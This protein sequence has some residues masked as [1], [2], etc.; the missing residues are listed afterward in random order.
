MATL[1]PRGPDRF[2]EAASLLRALANPVRLAI[3]DA[4]EDGEL[5]VHELVDALVAGHPMVTQPLVSQHLR[6]LRSAG[7]IDGTRRGREV[8]YRISD[9]HVSS[10]ARDAVSHAAELAPPD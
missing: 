6:V 5:C 8:A 10:I 2:A 7:L 1:P 9:T 3:V 4:L